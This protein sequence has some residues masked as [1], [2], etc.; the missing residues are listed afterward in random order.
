MSTR[1]KRQE[2][3]V[4]LLARHL[5]AVGPEQVLRRGYSITTLKKG[6]KV[7]RSVDQVRSG[8]RLVT[9]LADGEIESTA[10]D[11]NQPGLFES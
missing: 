9:R 5:T 3:K 1:L 10:E 11:K 6:G 8:D 2:L 7:A 4:D